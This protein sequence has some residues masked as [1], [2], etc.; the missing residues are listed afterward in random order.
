MSPA[1]AVIGLLLLLV[2]VIAVVAVLGLL[3]PPQ[4]PGTVELARELAEQAE[5]TGLPEVA[6]GVAQCP[7]PGLVDRE[8]SSTVLYECPDLFD[9]LVITYT[10]EVVGEVLQRDNGAWV[11]LN[12]DPYALSLGPLGSHGVAAGSNSGIG[13]FVPTET[14]QRISNVGGKE[15]QGDILTVRGV[16]QSADPED[17][18]SASIRALRVTDIEPGG[19]RPAQR[20]PGRR[21]AALVLL[22]VT[23]AVTVAAFR[24]QLADVIPLLRRRR[25]AAGDR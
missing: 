6:P 8:V 5:G 17:G 10:G 4:D 24:P 1:H 14:A 20:H 3:L 25:T 13:V 12:D 9:G 15:H 11:Q 2:A 22:P 18:G 7:V 23:L 21:I 16:F 19:E